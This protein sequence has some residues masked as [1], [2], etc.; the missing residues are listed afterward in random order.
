MRVAYPIEFPPGQLLGRF[1][2]IC[3]Q[4]PGTIMAQVDVAELRGLL[5]YA[6]KFHHDTNAAWETEAIND[7]ELTDF[8]ERVVLFISR[9]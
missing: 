3:N 5:D 6:N 1:I 4:R 2:G 8:A 9:R 7:A